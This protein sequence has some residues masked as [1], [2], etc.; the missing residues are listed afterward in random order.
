MSEIVL[1]WHF[2]PADLRLG[3]GDGR[4]VRVGETLRHEGPLVLCK[5]GMHASER[6]IDALVYASG[7]VICRVRCG[8]E[9]LR[10]SDK[11]VCRERTVEWMLTDTDDLL[12]GFARWCAR[13]V[14]HMWK[15]PEIVR[16]YLEAGDES[17]RDAAGA[18]AEDAAWAAGDAA[19]AAAGDAAWAARDAAGAAAGDAAWAARDAAR[20]AEDAAGAAGDAARATAGAAAWDAQNAELERL[21]MEAHDAIIES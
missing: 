9:I 2:L 1:A 21:V 12:C 8:G 3:N 19:G 10:D 16:R 11:L 4:E 7:P 14:L 13:S 17:L 18:A 5:S 15:A 6:I 20:A